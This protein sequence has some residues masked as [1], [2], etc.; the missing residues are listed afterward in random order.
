MRGTATSISAY[1]QRSGITPACAGN[2]SINVKPI[3]CQQD[4]PRV[5]G[6][7]PY[8]P[9]P[10]YPASGSPPR[11]R[12]TD[13]QARFWVYDERITPA[14]AG[15]SSRS[16]ADNQRKRDHPRVCGEQ[17]YTLPY[18]R[19]CKGSPPRVRGTVLVL[20]LLSNFLGSPP[21]VRGTALLLVQSTRASRITPACA[22]NRWPAAR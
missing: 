21:R 14:C 16:Q 7:Q 10:P 5:C 11:V 8:R 18:R 6:E 9:I 12:G 15:N 22:G 19:S 20:G 2:S 4:H 1:A 3:F 17:R 13:Q